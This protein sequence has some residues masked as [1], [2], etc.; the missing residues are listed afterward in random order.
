MQAKKQKAGDREETCCESAGGAPATPA[1][2]AAPAAHP[3]AAA[4]AR[5]AG[6]ARPEHPGPLLTWKL[7]RRPMT[8]KLRR[9]RSGNQ[10][11]QKTMLSTEGGSSWRRRQRA[12]LWTRRSPSKLFNRDVVVGFLD[13]VF[14]IPVM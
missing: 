14:G 7:R 11:D 9:R 10:S 6:G 13:W 1:A 4:S 3:A 8:W 5:A 2:P 12:Q